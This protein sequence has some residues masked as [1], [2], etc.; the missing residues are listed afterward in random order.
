MK[1]RSHLLTIVLATLLPVLL[2]AVV[3]AVLFARQQQAAVRTAL[4]ETAEALTIAVDR[5][6]EAS[7]TTL[8]ALATSRA[9][10]ARDVAGFYAEAQGLR[11]E[12]H[13]AWFDVALFDP[14]G[15][16]ILSLAAPPG[17]PQPSIADLGYFQDVLR[18]RRPA[19]SDLLPARASEPPTVVIAVPVVRSGEIRYVVTASV[20]SDTWSRLLAEQGP[21][22]GWAVRVQDRKLVTIARAP[23]DPE[24]VGQPPGPFEEQIRGRTQGWVKSP[25]RRGLVYI[26]FV[27]SSLSGWVVAVG[28]PADAVEGPLYRSLAA[29]TAGGLLLVG[30]AVGFAA[31]AGRRLARSIR[32]LSASAE[33]LGRGENT[34]R[35]PTSRVAEVDALAGTIQAAAAARLAAEDALR[36]SEARWL[37]T[38]HS[39]GDGVIA[40]DAAGRVSLM[41]PV[42]ESLTGWRQAEA[43]GV[44]LEQ[45]FR[46]V[47]EVARRPV[48]SSVARVMREGSVVGLGVGTILLARSGR[49]IPIDDSGAPIRDEQGRILGAVLVFRD[50]TERKQA[51]EALRETTQLLEALVRSSGL[52]IVVL[53][54]DATV[55]L[56]NPAAERIFGW[57]AAEAIGRPLPVILPQDWAA[58]RANL[59]RSLAGDVVDVEVRRHRK[60]GTAVD[61]AVSTAPL[62]DAAGRIRG[63]VAVAGDVTERKR[64][65][66][67]RGLL[68]AESERRQKEAEVLAELARGIGAARDLDALLQHVVEGSRELAAGDLAHIAL[69]DP[70]SGAMVFRYWAGERRQGAQ[71]YEIT[72]GRG[73]GGQVLL[74]GRPFRTADYARD[75]RISADLLPT[76][77]VEGIVASMAVPIRID[78]VIEGLLFVDNRTPRSFTDRDEVLLTRLADHAAVAIRNVRLLSREQAARADAEAASR[79]KD[80]FLAML[81]HEL[82]NPLGAIAHAMM[83]LDRISKQDERGTRLRAIVGRQTRHLARLVDDLLDVTR[84]STGKIQLQ[85]LPTDLRAVAE[86]GLASLHEAG[87]TSGHTV[88]L[89]GDPVVVEGDATRLEQVVWN[90]LDNALKYTPP[91][92]RI[93]VEVVRDAGEAVLRVRD[94][95][96]GIAPEILP[97]IFELFVQAHASLDRAQGGLGLGLA[98]VRRLVEL[99]G[100]RVAATSPGPGKG[101]EFIVRLPALA[102]SIETAMTPVA[103]EPTAP[104]SSRRILLVED[105]ADVRDGLRLLLEDWGHRVDEAV[106]GPSG[107]TQALQGL[108][109]LAL[110][111][112]GLPGLDGYGVARG[113]RSAPGGDSIRLVALTGYGQPE[114]RR[115]ALEAGFDAHLVKPVEPDDLLRLLT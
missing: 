41:N 55:R 22:Q 111:D 14:G 45:V 20:A 44:P 48:E 69:R 77:Q 19:I 89:V 34:S 36:R 90:L 79:A 35:A 81:G 33:A 107:L 5:E 92:G 8:R 64:E 38:L 114:D 50:I 1:L 103:V 57:S 10:G 52:G 4:Q 6:L 65:Q 85:R 102:A 108:P 60:D 42:A 61:L 73:I 39:I 67:E 15:R 49:E 72:P 53:D 46:I 109:D 94:S 31:L 11:A 18:T 3:M 76:V 75:P 12:A 105:N 21:P 97:R 16:G 106:D 28:I 70:A 13:P 82:R 99:H 112:V 98:L 26:A 62:R 59:E 63:V 23:A 25:T 27:R 47:D 2:F 43:A 24:L 54:S 96:S 71:G 51:D 87:K 95:G 40:T 68:Y 113:I 84:L 32:A 86:R 101:S 9:L 30:L 66:A 80:E 88:G 91:G 110:I 78:E 56:W 115:R 7:I 17:A 100:G 104:V 29:V 37:A 74:T 93:D 58:F 83:V